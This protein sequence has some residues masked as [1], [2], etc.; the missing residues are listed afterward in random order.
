MVILS[1]S[2]YSM[3]HL[4]I[5]IGNADNHFHQGGNAF[6]QMDQNEDGVKEQIKNWGLVNMVDWG[7]GKGDYGH[8]GLRIGNVKVEN[9]KFD[10][11][12]S[13]Q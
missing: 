6:D 5:E 8:W 11:P 9:G 7:L 3:P 1:L 12:Y 10:I 4:Y 2:L 13:I